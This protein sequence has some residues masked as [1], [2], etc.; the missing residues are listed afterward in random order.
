MLILGCHDL[1]LFSETREGQSTDGIDPPAGA[2][3]A[4]RTLAQKVR[5]GLRCYSI[6]PH[7]GTVR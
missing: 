5:A 7:D 1:N 2:C 3:D 4:M 6:P